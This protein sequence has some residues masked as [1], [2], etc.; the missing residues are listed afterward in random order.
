MRTIHKYEITQLGEFDVMMPHGSIIRH[1]GID[2][3]GRICLWAEVDSSRAN[4]PVTIFLL[5]TGQEIPDEA[6]HYIGSVTVGIF[7]WHAYGSIK[8]SRK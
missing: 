4:E 8:P 6:G 5:G 3:H 2:P 7:V 1:F